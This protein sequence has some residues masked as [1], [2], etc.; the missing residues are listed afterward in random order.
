MKQFKYFLIVWSLSVFAYAETDQL[1]YPHENN[2]GKLEALS[3]K[4][5]VETRNSSECQAL[6]A[7]MEPGE[8]LRKQLD[9]SSQG[10]SFETSN[11]FLKD[12]AQGGWNFVEDLGVSMIEGLDL[13]KEIAAEQEC[14]KDPVSKR[15]IFDDYNLAVPEILRVPKLSDSQLENMHCGMIRARLQE[16]RE[17]RNHQVMSQ[18]QR[19]RG[20]NLD[21][22][23]QEFVAYR[24]AQRKVGPGLIERA[25]ELLKD[26]K[27]QPQCYNTQVYREMLCEA[28]ASVATTFGGGAGIAFKA[29]K[30]S[31][32][33][34]LSGLR[35]MGQ[36]SNTERI[37]Y[38]E[39]RLTEIWGAEGRVLS[40]AQKKA[41][42][43]AHEVGAGSGRGYYSYTSQELRE[44]SKI[45]ERAG[46]DRYERELLMREG[47]TG[48]WADEVFAT[49]SKANSLRLDAEKAARDGKIEASV[50]S[51]KRSAQNLESIM[52]D[53]KVGKTERDYWVAAKINA[54]AKDYD[55]AAEYFI[56][57][58]SRDLR[59]DQRAQAIFE[60]LNREKDELRVRASQ[61]R[62]MAG[63]QKDYED[64]RKLIEALIKRP[65]FP[66]SDSI[67]RELLKP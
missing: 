17:K 24:D 38:A 2:L 21:V 14:A 6:Y 49:R 26:L 8:V 65:D 15:A 55:K 4:V 43:D 39:K 19:K 42:I 28:V 22:K 61:N 36:L 60:S 51:Y 67:K 30:A 57:T 41:I 47:V 50:E 27:V 3:D 52:K 37:A 7:K 58:Q 40:D 46:F 33:A 63:A 53:P 18:V 34:K 20:Q 11:S 9:C 23:E 66:T 10:T 35:K 45:L 56:K 13:R 54:G 31:K 64:H 32:I 12:C 16:A 48:Q 59:S 62:S 1:C 44:K 5:C 25:K 29:A